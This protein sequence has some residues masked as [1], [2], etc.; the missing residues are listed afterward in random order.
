MLG[1]GAGAF[2]GIAGPFEAME[3]HNTPIDL[4]AMGGVVGLTAVYYYPV[5]NAVLAYNR[6]MTIL[7]PLLAGLIVFTMFHFVARHPVFW[8]TVF[9]TVGTID[10]RRSEAPH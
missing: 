1:N 2:S 8:F 4:L 7:F 5:R 3:A 6:G 9:A 10:A